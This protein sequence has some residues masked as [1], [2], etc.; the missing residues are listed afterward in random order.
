L[1][2]WTCEQ[3]MFRTHVLRSEEQPN[4]KWD[5]IFIELSNLNVKEK[6]KE[7]RWKVLVTNSSVTCMHFNNNIKKRIHRHVQILIG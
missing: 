4:K 5:F 6:K 1:H 2:D 3:T 7:R